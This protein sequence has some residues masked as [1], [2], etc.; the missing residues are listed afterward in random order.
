MFLFKM[1]VA[2]IEVRLWQC[3]SFENQGAIGIHESVVGRLDVYAE[4]ALVV[5]LLRVPEIHYEAPAGGSGRHL[6]ALMS[7]HG[8]VC[9]PLLSVLEG[10]DSSVLQVQAQQGA[11]RQEERSHSAADA[12]AMTLK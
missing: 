5:V 6:K 3:P 11:V 10:V 7:L 12:V 1:G 8:V 4:P 9:L 2:E